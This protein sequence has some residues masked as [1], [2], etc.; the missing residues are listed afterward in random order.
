M[1]ICSLVVHAK[2][3]LAANVQTRLEE[4]PGVEIHGGQAEGKLV[5]TVEDCDG[6]G[7]VPDTMA[8]F[9]DVKGVLNTVLI[10]HYGADETLDEEKTE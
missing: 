5:V 10:Y 1:N 8:A 7:S 3:H 9:N 4:F 6:A 2:P